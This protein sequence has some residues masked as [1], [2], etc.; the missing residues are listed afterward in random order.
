MTNLSNK[1][2][3]EVL[4]ILYEKIEDNQSIIK[5]LQRKARFA[6]FFGIIKWLFYIGVAVGVYTYFQPLIG[7]LLDTYESIRESAGVLG[8]LKSEIPNLNN[9]DFLR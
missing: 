6:A 2:D 5:S 8:N 4:E 1:T 7:N 9:L 3:R